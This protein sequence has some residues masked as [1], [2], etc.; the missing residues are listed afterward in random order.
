MSKFEERI[1]EKEN[2]RLSKMKEKV[3]DLS[4]FVNE[5]TAK[6]I[7]KKQKLVKH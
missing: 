1:I 2:E 3:V 6:N 7:K 5:E 4:Y